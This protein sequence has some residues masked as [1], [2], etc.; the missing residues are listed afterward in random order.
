M[1]KKEK[2]NEGS[3][4]IHSWADG[5]EDRGRKGPAD[6]ELNVDD[7]PISGGGAPTNNPIAKLM[8]WIVELFTLHEA[9][10]DLMKSNEST[11]ENR[12]VEPVDPPE[13][14]P[15]TWFNEDFEKGQK[16]SSSRHN[17]KSVAINRAVNELNKNNSKDSIRLSPFYGSAA[18]NGQIRT[19]NDTIIKR[20]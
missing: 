7:F 14:K 17:T 6:G 4:N 8:R 2:S 1:K 18:R 11:M 13:Q 20:N 10:D 3:G 19:A 12:N 9:A 5:W 16:V 15:D